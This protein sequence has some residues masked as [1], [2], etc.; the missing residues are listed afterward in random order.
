[1]AKA[2][3]EKIKLVSTA[4]TGIFIQLPKTAAPCRTNWSSRNLT[5][6]PESMCCTRKRR[7]SNRC[8]CGNQ[9]KPAVPGFFVT[10]KKSHPWA[11]TGWAHD[12]DERFATRTVQ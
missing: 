11:A 5:R 10:R 12:P 2:I 4:D 8:S 9:K 7:S 3:R 6:L 1:M